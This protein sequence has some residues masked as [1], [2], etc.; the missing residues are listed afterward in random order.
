MIVVLFPRWSKTKVLIA[1][2][3]MKTP[4]QISYS[5]KPGI[6]LIHKLATESTT[7]RL[8]ATQQRVNVVEIFDENQS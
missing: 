2:L 4:T 8:E 3:R 6:F 7:K 5:Y 1:V